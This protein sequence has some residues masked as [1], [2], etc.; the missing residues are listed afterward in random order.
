[1]DSLE[2][3][4]L[5]ASSDDVTKA[6]DFTALDRVA[7]AQRTQVRVWDCM[8]ARA[9]VCVCVHTCARVCVGSLLCRPRHAARA[10]RQPPHTHAAA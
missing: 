3:F 8:R 7:A 1:M 5:I 2:R 4:L 6:I 9:R 10:P